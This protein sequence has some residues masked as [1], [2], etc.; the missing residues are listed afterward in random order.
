[1][2]DLQS[3]VKIAVGGKGGVGKTTISAV[4]ARLF[5]QDGFEV[6]AVDADPNTS[7]CGAFG[8]SPADSPQPLIEMKQLIAERTGTDKDAVGAYFRLNP[9]V[10]DLPE[11]F[12]IEVAGDGQKGVK[13]LVL[14]AIKHG[15]A[16]CA[17]PEGAFLKAMLTHTILQRR[18]LVLVDLAAGPEFL[19]RAS[20]QGIDALI[21]VVEPG[22]RSLETAVNIAR[23]G[24]ELGVKNVVGIANKITDASQIEAIKSR[25]PDLNILTN[26]DYS[27]EIQKTDLGGGNIFTAD[28]EVVKKI[29][30]AKDA[31]TELIMADAGGE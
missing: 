6:L 23:M 16:G 12:S 28:S 5:A 30:Q 9:K 20:I 15:G 22:S 31:L 14:G 19:G 29:S 8:V 24:R 1:V 10:H 13:V 4:L 27:A 17:C 26:I 11:K 7:L 3:G 18:E 21:I 25:L 2:K